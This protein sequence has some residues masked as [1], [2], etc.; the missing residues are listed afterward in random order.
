ML[1]RVAMVIGFALFTACGGGQPAA[2][3]PGSASSPLGGPCVADSQCQSGLFCD[4]DDPGGQC[5]KKC[6]SSADCGDGVCS[7]E[8]KCYRSCQNNEDCGR[9]GYVC[10]GASPHKF[11]DAAGEG[12]EHDEK[13]H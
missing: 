13:K 3:S 10:G 12:D 8:K 6:A 5:L 7:D 11:C 1:G 9:T 2:Q 4:K